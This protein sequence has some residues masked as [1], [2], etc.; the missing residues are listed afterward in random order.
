MAAI[1]QPAKAARLPRK[2]PAVAQE[3]GKRKGRPNFCASDLFYVGVR[4]C[5]SSENADK[6]CAALRAELQSLGVHP[7]AEGLAVEVSPSM[8]YC[9]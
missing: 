1:Y 5:I 7:R 3:R 4:N 6:S 8:I 9:I 2:L